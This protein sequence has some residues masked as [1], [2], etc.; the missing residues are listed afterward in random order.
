MGWLLSG[1]SA[2]INVGLHIRETFNEDMLILL[3]LSAVLSVVWK[4]TALRPTG[5]SANFFE[6]FNA[7]SGVFTVVRS[8]RH[9]SRKANVLECVQ[10]GGLVEHSQ[11]GR[12]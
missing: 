6:P 4:K 8:M 12:I 1:I 9:A 7:P 11:G 2:E 3:K 10:R 5:K